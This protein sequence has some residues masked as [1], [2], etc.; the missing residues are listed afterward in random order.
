MSDIT[1][2]YESACEKIG[3]SPES[4]ISM[5]EL[6]RAYH[7]K[8]LQY[9]PDKNV[10]KEAADEFKMV[11]AAYEYTMKENGYM[12]DDDMINTM[13]YEY[14]CA[15]EEKESY[16]PFSKYTNM[17]YSF[18]DTDAF[19]GLKS[20]LLE[21]LIENIGNKCEEKALQILEHINRTQFSKIRELLYV[22]QMAFHI[23]ETFLEKMDN[24]Y[25]NKFDND[26]CVRLYPTLDDLLNENVY[27]LVHEDHIFYV[28]L[29]HHELVY[30]CSGKDLY[31]QCL[32]QLDEGVEIDEKNNIHVTVK[33]K[34]CDIWKMKTISLQ[35]GSKPAFTGG[36]SCD[37]HNGGSSKTIHIPRSEL[38]MEAKQTITMVQ[39]GISRI[40][41]SNIY[42]VS[43]KGNI[44]V[45]I[46]IE[47]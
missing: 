36:G 11:H 19:Q 39:R 15:Q 27:K 9:H 46:E 28:P 35:L 2:T 21:S 30:D 22:N 29:W 12:D 4:D 14:T 24:L 6:K 32:P 7:K 40:H 23:P 10:G 33:H 25:S 8:A 18:L 26:E 45:H 1:F 34:L 42:D 31:V 44:I 16:P 13:E 43:K 5:K 20:K 41:P 3:L 47:H 37:A 17:L 38:K